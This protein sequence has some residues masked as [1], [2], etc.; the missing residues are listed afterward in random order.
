MLWLC[1]FASFC[2]GQTLTKPVPDATPIDEALEAYA[3]LTHRTV[4]RPTSLP[5]GDASIPAALPENTNAALRV[6]EDRVTNAGIA[7]VRDGTKFVRALPAEWENTPGPAFL[8]TLQRPEAGGENIP[9]G[10]VFFPGADL[11]MVLAVYAQIR[12]RTVLRSATINPRPIKF[13]NVTDLTQEELGYGLTVA[14]ALNGIAALDDG[15]RFVQVVPVDEWRHVELRA[16][17]RTPGAT[18]L[19]PKVLPTCPG[20]PPWKRTSPQGPPPPL[21]GLLEY[22]GSLCAKSVVEEGLQG[23]WPVFFAI[24]QPVTREE[25]R[26][27]ILTSLKLGGLAIVDSD[28]HSLRAISLGELRGLQVRDPAAAA[29]VHQP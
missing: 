11:H 1:C 8:S 27:A 14:L 13:R 25:A 16:P 23:D 22:Y 6:L 24:T 19:D 9:A 17:R 20:S 15:D 28:D 21:K 29:K 10:E 3:R 12:A 18:L 4:L 2:S 5:R 7:L 26:Y